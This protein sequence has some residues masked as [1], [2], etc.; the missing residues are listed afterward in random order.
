MLDASG[1]I[2][3]KGISIDHP[4]MMQSRLEQHNEVIR[5][6]DQEIKSL[7]GQLDSCEEQFKELEADMQQ[8]L[9]EK[10]EVIRSLREGLT[11]KSELIDR[12][13]GDHAKELAARDEKYNS[14][15]KAFEG[16]GSMVKSSILQL[17]GSSFIPLIIYILGNQR[18]SLTCFLPFL[19]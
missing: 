2:K 13:K 18:E 14:L 16:F 4:E 8:R 7:K 17:A 5:D 10:D 9:M 6:Q 15:F 3:G 19:S 1:S 11:L 12:L